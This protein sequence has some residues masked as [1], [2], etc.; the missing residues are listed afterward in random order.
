MDSIGSEHLQLESQSFVEAYG[1]ELAGTV[2]DKLRDADV[3]R[4][5][6]DRNDVAMVLLQHGGQKRLDCP[7]VGQCVDAERSLNQVIRRVE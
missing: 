5:T 3:T 7:E 2:I 6:G 4:H 1:C